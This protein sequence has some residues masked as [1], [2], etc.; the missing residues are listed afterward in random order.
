MK[1]K[2][3]KTFKIQIQINKMTLNMKLETKKVNS[4][5]HLD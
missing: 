1:Y 5:T 2:T 3:N 4:N